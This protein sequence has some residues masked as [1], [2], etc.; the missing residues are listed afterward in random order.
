MANISDDHAADGIPVR[1]CLRDLRLHGRSRAVRD[2]RKRL[3]CDRCI[4]RSAVCNIPDGQNTRADMNALMFQQL[5][6]DAARDAQ[7]RSQ[8]SGKMPAA[9]RVLRAAEFNLRRIIRVAGAGDIL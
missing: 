7:R 1:L 3:V 6:A 8:P 9:V 4:K 5:H 2:R